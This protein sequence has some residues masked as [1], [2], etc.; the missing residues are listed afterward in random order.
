MVLQEEIRLIFTA[1]NLELK[2]KEI[3]AA[4]KE[5]L[6]SNEKLDCG[7]AFKIAKKFNKNIEEIGQIADENQIRIDNCELGQFGHLEFEKPKIE[8]LK[9]LEPKLD[10]KRRIFCKDARELAKKHYNLKSIRSALKSYKI[11]VK[12]CLLGCFK[13]KRGKKFVVKTK[14]WIE[15]ADGDLLF[16]KGKTE[17]LEL[18]AQ[19][20]SLLHASKIMGINYK[21][22]WTHLQVLQ[23][24]SQEDLVVT[25][26]GRSKDSGTK[27]TPRAIELMENYSLLQKD[28]EEYAN[29][30]FKEL[31][32]K[33]KKS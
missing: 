18:I 12:Y 16:G 30:R 33:D 14:T 19:T 17:L 11:D 9:I 2:N 22:A 6:N 27:L 21:K 15:N 31:F 23:K 3:I 8:V 28:I 24:N 32:L 29:K 1:G 7:T 10:E 20:G 4:M 25:K 5:L 13:E 26:Q